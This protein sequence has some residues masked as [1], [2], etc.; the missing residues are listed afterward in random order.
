MNKKGFRQQMLIKMAHSLIEY[1]VN[2]KEELQI[3][4]EM[5]QD[6]PLIFANYDKILET[7]KNNPKEFKT[8]DRGDER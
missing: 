8:Y 2:D 5:L 4:D 6:F 1:K 7:I 3:I